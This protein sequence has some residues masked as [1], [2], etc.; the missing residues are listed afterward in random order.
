MNVY[1]ELLFDEL[2]T[3]CTTG[4]D[5]FDISAHLDDQ[6]FK[7]YAI[8]LWAMHDFLGLGVASS[9]QTQGL[10]A[11]PICGPNVLES[12]QSPALKKVI[13]TGYRKYLP[14]GHRLRHPRY[15]GNYGHKSAGRLPEKRRSSAQFWLDQL[16]LV[17]EKKLDKNRAGVKCRSILHGLLYYK[18]WY[19]L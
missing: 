10:K 16:Q 4:V 7:L 11:C 19:V 5:A 8:L 6:K 18:V 1:L 2:M 13:Y 14:Y 17:K 15:N 3:L 12:R 9:L